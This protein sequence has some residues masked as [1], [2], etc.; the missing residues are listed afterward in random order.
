MPYS[1]SYLAHKYNKYTYP[2]QTP[3][4]RELVSH[5]KDVLQKKNFYFTGRFADWDGAG[6]DGQYKHDYNDVV[7]NNSEFGYAQI[8]GAAGRFAYSLDYIKGNG[9]AN[10]AAAPAAS[11]GNTDE[12]GLPF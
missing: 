12:D 2:V 1:P 3:H 11:T 7:G 6:E 4:T 10:A 5:L 9:N 8:N